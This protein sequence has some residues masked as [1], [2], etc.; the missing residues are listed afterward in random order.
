[1]GWRSTRR[2]DRV[3]QTFSVQQIQSVLTWG[4]QS[5]PGWILLAV[6][7]KVASASSGVRAVLEN[8]VGMSSLVQGIYSMKWSNRLFPTR[9]SQSE[10][11]KT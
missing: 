3:V 7:I 1:M 5:T 4:M 6:W 11:A 2:V 9:T 10:E 8:K